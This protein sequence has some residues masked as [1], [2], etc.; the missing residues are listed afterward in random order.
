MALSG[1]FA[2]ND[3]T[4]YSDIDLWLFMPNPEDCIPDYDLHYHDGFLVSISRTTIE[5]KRNDLEKPDSAIWA[6]MGIQQAKTL[7]DPSHL[8]AELQNAA[9]A[10]DWQPLQNEA[11]QYA[12]THLRGLIEEA[13]K[14]LTGLSTQ[15][16]ST[17]YIATLGMTLGLARLMAVQHGLLM[18]TENEYERRIQESAGLTSKWTRLYRWAAGYDC[19]ANQISPT[20]FRAIA[21]LELYIKTARRLRDVLDTADSFVIN[22][23]VTIIT[24]ANYQLPETP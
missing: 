19:P 12:S 4:Q 21:A 3:A 7:F 20:A 8:F 5:Q 2:R 10:F 11:N 15:N 24:Q 14:I 6:V 9:N 13:H 1:S 17:T 23:T 22:Q 16:E 18:H